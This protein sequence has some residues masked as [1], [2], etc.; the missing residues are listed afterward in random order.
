[1]LKGVARD[2]LKYIRTRMWLQSQWPDPEIVYQHGGMLAIA[3]LLRQTSSTVL[4]NEIL[5][6]FGASIDPECWPIGPGLT[7]HEYGDS[8]A[9]LTIGKHVHIGKEVF[10]DLT[11]PIIIEDSV[12]IGMRTIILTHMILGDYPN[13]PISKIYPKVRKPT[14]FRRGCSV[15]AGCVVASGVEIGEDAIINANILIDKDVP[16]RTVVNSGRVRKPMR[17]PDRLFDRQKAKD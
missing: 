16:P 6:R 2:L 15:G 10:F 13:K 14:V 5:R 17:L 12:G 9:N 1:M 4:T 11:E 8:F 3:N 7:M